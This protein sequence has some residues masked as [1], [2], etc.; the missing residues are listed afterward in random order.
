MKKLITKLLGLD[1]LE[2][3]KETLQ[4]INDTISESLKNKEKYDNAVKRIA[5]LE[6]Q[7]FNEQTRADKLKRERNDLEKKVRE[8]NE[9]DIYLEAAKIMK[10]IENGEKVTH[11]DDSYTELY[12]AYKNSRSSSRGIDM[13]TSSLFGTLGR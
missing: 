8:Q 3:K 11:T 12:N 4:K 1:T 9:A 7:F 13:S 5:E 6:Q 10:R 2:S